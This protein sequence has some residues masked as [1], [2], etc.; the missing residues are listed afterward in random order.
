MKILITDCFLRKSFDVY[1][2]VKLHYNVEDIIIA[3]NQKHTLKA[4]AIYRKKIFPLRKNCQA[5]FNLDIALISNI[6][7]NEKILY[8][9][10]EEDTTMFFY[11]FISENQSKS[12]LYRLPSKES[13]CIAQDK[14]L[15]TKFCIENQIPAPQYFTKD[16][17]SNKKLKTTPVI[18]KPRIGS[19]S[20]NIFY[21]DNCINIE[22]LGIPN[23]DNFVIQER[24]LNGKD[25]VGAFFL[26]EHGKVLSSYCHKRERTFPQQGG[27]T[28]FSKIYESNEPIETGSK[29]LAMLD[30]S[31]FAMIEFLWDD[32]TRQ[33]KII[34]L[35]PRIWGSVILSEFSG[36]NFIANYIDISNGRPHLGT[37]IHQAAIR[38][39]ELDLLNIFKPGVSLSSFFKLDINN[40]CYINWT[41]AGFW[42]SILF[43]LFYYINVNSLKSLIKK[44]KR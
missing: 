32:K 34:E 41:Y 43:H 22:H 16:Q 27:V 24:L 3:D 42:S 12:F 15:L 6:Y 13:F 5:N 38:W 17:I 37:A 21:A 2:I 14:F 30:W 26:C 40:T 9:P 39:L 18:I 28:V 7:P 4:W 8:L 1:N 23:L 20:K 44:C 36:A 33:Y 25:V 35:N 11:G 19:G 29:L 10:V 31:G